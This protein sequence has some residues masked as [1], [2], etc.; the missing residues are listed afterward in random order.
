METAEITDIR[1]YLTF[2]LGDEIFAVDVAQVREILELATITKV[3]KTPEFMRGVIN[4][5]GS[6]VPVVDMRLKFG[7]SRGEETINSCI[8]VM[9]VSLDSETTVIGA[10]VDSVQEVSE[11]APDQIEPAPRLGT[12]MNVEFIKGIGKHDEDF[13]IILEIDR[14]FSTVELASVQDVGNGVMVE[15]ASKKPE[16]AVAG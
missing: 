6:V 14:I 2:K 7:M 1:Q 3:P 9:E 5:R 4:V 8:V 12:Q 13:V 11:F 15:K 16:E 10:L